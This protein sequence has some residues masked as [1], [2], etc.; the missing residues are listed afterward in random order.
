MPQPVS[1]VYR[2]THDTMFMPWSAPGSLN[3]TSAS[4]ATAAN[5]QQAGP[6]AQP[7]GPNGGPSWFSL[8]VDRRVMRDVLRKGL[9][10]DVHYNK[11]FSHY[12]TT[13]EKVTAHFSD[14]SSESGRLLVGADGVYSKLAAQ[15]T[16]GKAVPRD[17]HIRAIYGKSPLTPELEAML[18]KELASGMGIVTDKTKNLMMGMFFE[19]MRFNHDNTPQDY[20]YWVLSGEAADMGVSD[21]ALLGATGPEAAQIAQRVTKDWLPGYKAA[22]EMQDEKETQTMKLRCSNPE[23][24]PRWDRES[25]VTIMGDAIHAMPPTGGAANVALRDAA[26]L[27]KAIQQGWANS[28]D[29]RTLDDALASYEEEMLERGTRAVKLAYGGIVN[30]FG[31]RPLDKS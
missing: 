4:G 9:D 21:E 22:M 10:K 5:A 13:Q 11:L 2:G 29:D 12:S 14:G 28:D 15:L 25:R 6:N 26:E 23:G 17:L 20:F 18:D 8:P 31:A 3:S 16:G 1:R 27:S 7:S 19:P 24:L 30:G